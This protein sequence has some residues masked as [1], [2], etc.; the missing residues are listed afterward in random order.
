MKNKHELPI[1]PNEISEDTKV[2]MRTRIISGVVAAVIALPILIFGDYPL[3]ALAIFA[4][5]CCIYE[6]IKCAGKKYS[7]WLYIISFILSISLTFWPIIISLFN[8]L[9]GGILPN[10][11]YLPIGDWRIFSQFSTLLIPVSTLIV[12]VVALFF[13]VVFDPGFEVRDACY[14]FTMVLIV[15]MGL[16][17]VLFLRYIPLYEKYIQQGVEITSYFSFFDNFE[18]SYLLMFVMIG[19]FMSDIG[20]YF[21][22]VFFGKHK[23]NPR[24]SPKKT[25]EGFFGGIIVS[26][27]SS[28]AFAFILA[29]CNHPI[30][31]FLDISHWY[32]ILI[33]S[34]TIP[35]FAVLGDFVFS[36]VKRSFGV[37]DFGKIMPGHGG[38]LD[39]IDSILFSMMTSAVIISLAIYWM[40]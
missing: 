15:S 8:S 38:I 3:L 31:S 35:P 7:V 23:M 9:T 37:K 2:S 27:L 33:L 18:S 21:I 19:T 34:L 36:S 20:A 13:T 10:L 6:A 25:W 4:L 32:L 30:L 29:L 17:S 5:A 39:R 1:Q 24:I 16:Q 11:D 14:V 28:F 26:A 22:G 12:G 40:K